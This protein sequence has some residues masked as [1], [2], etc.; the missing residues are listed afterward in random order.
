MKIFVGNLSWDATEDL[1][2]EEFQKFG[3]LLSVRIVTDPQSGRSRG[4]AFIEFAI[5]E[6]GNKAVQEMDNFALLGRPIRVSKA[7]Q[8]DRSAGPR[9][10]GS[11]AGA[12]SFRG[13]AR[14][15]AGQ[16]PSYRQNRYED[17]DE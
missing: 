3:E 11:R 17:S 8:E 4:F 6:A 13:G 1:L 5:E 2:R 14:S 10:G 12:G 16:R 9:T 15:G 7:R